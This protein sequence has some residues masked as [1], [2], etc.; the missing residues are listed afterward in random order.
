MITLTLA[1]IIALIV[2]VAAFVV[3]AL[4]FAWTIVAGLL[5]LIAKPF[6]WLYEK[7]FQ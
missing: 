5:S 6:I 4:I 3:Y 2:V 1:F 7:I